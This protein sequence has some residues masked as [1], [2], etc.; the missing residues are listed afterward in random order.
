METSR[1]SPAGSVAGRGWVGTIRPPDP[2]PAEAAAAVV[3][4]EQFLR[5]TAPGIAPNPEPALSQ[6]KREALAEG[7]IR[8]P[9]DA[10]AS[11]S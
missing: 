1:S 11:A 9:E 10:T 2:T 5:D 8:W 7:V 6:W 3:A 4:I